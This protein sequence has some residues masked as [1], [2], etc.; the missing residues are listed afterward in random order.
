VL[1]GRPRDPVHTHRAACADCDG[2]VYLGDRQW[3]M[4]S[5]RET[6]MVVR[7]QGCLDSLGELRVRRDLVMQRAETL[8]LPYRE[9]LEL[10]AARSS[11]KTADFLRNA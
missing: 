3:A 10:A 5:R 8:K 9:L 7:C 2:D 6:D 4:W 11:S 1:L